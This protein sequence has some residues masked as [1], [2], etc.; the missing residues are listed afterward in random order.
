MEKGSEKL[1]FPFCIICLSYTNSS[2]PRGRP[3]LSQWRHLPSHKYFIMFPLFPSLAVPWR[4]DFPCWLTKVFCFPSQKPHITRLQGGTCPPYFSLLL[5]NLF[6]I[7]YKQTLS[8]FVAK[9]RYYSMPL[10]HSGKDDKETDS[11]VVWAKTR[12]HPGRGHGS[13]WGTSE[14][15][16]LDVKRLCNNFLFWVLWSW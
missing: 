3:A 1:V 2:V 16:V 15:N 5:P 4:L 8:H 14:V 6:S 7:S 13:F 10:S 11:W 12:H 9:M